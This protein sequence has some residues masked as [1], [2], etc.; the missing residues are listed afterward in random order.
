MAGYWYIGETPND[1]T[2]R[3]LLILGGMISLAIA[4]VFPDTNWT[5]ALPA[6]SFGSTAS[7]DV[8]GDGK[9]ELIFTTYTND[10]KAHCLNAEDGSVRWVFDIGGC[11][12]VA[13]VIYDLD[14]DDTL[15]VFING[16]CNPTCFCINA[17][18]GVLKWS[19]AS[20]GGDS[21]PTVADIDED[22]KPEV[23]FG[24]FSGQV[25]ILNGE[26]GSLNRVFTP[27]SGIGAIQT[28]PTIGDLDGD[29]H[30]DFIV[31][32]HF[33]T[34][35]FY[36]WAY[37]YNAGD[38]MWTNFQY[39]TSATYYS[40]HGGVL[41]DMDNDTHLEYVIGDNAGGV[42]GLNAEDGT[43]QW[44]VTGY[45]NVISAISCANFDADA[46]LEIVFSNNDYLT[47]D[48]RIWVLDGATGVVEWSYPVSSSG[49][50]GVAISDIN[51]NG[52]LDCV[53]GHYMGDIFAVEPFTGLIWTYDIDPLLPTGLPY[54]DVDH[55]PVVADFDDN[56][57]MDVFMI[58]GY[59]TY[60][61]D[62]QNVGIAICIEAGNNASGCPEWL[63]FRQDVQRSGYLSASDIAA[64]CAI[65]G[66][67]E[68]LQSY[69]RLYPNPSS[70]KVT[71]QT[72]SEGTFMLYDLQ[73]RMCNTVQVPAG[74]ID[75]WLGKLPAGTYIWSLIND[76][77]IA[78]GRLVIAP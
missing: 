10:G 2:N 49:F 32:N 50:R 63:M 1:M 30:L 54:W 56:G 5:Y 44:S 29:G 46:N 35:G 21:P 31:C 41:A 52:K 60:I 38:T 55:G 14:M 40:Y 47:Y 39:D 3:L 36:T 70:G 73:G 12:D 27:A 61:P 57:T 17:M 68:Q 67:D 26:D 8:D 48:D 18:T 34:S 37:D 6:P 72:L 22:G 11:G 7:A 58:G 71:I 24:N 45:T 59:G 74:A 78:R 16:S 19:V 25:R 65:V 23:L 43:V 20:G 42:R 15:D 76:L 53:S 66:M 62:S 77:Q 75:I 33:N 28:E 64:S 4:Q 69:V 51:G 13:P 9:L